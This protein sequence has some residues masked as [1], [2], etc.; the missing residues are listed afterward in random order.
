MRLIS[1]MF[2]NWCFVTFEIHEKHF[3]YTATRVERVSCCEFN[4]L[5]KTGLWVFWR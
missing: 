5:V 4:G 1:R 2:D 3:K